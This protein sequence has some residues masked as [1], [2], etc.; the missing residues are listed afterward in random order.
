MKRF[1]YILIV[2]VLL[3]ACKDKDD[4]KVAQLADDKN[5]TFSV[6][7]RGLWTA[8]THP[9]NYPANAKFGKVI[10][11]THHRDYLLFGEGHR[12]SNWLKS[13]LTTENTTTFSSKLGEYQKNGNAGAV[14]VNDG[15]VASENTNFEF[16][17]SGRFDKLT[18]LTKLTPSP[19]W[20]IAVENV[21]LNR[22]AGGGSLSIIVNVFDG[23]VKSG[24]SYENAGND[25]N[26]NITYM[27]KSPLAYPNG[28]V[29]KLA[30][31]QIALKNVAEKK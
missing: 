31:V 7:I 10:G 22:L 8:K 26:E 11:A 1:F 25:T 30:I 6:T 14:I 20:Y 23:G 3:T 13:Y 28:G 5:Y 9:T 18:L 21:N 15:F 4:K 27:N 24:Q 29:N 2:G 16:T 12:A 19:D 17:T